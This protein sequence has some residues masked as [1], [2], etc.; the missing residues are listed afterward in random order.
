MIVDDTPANL[1]LLMTILAQEGYRVRPMTQGEAAIAAARAVRPDLI[2][3]DIMMPQMDGYEV[4]RRLKADEETRTIPIIFLSAMDAT[5]S[6]VR[7]FQAGA[8]DFI[9]KPF[10]AEE[11]VARVKTHLT[12]RHLQ[13]ELELRLLDLEARNEELNAFSHTVAHDLKNPVSNIVGFAELLDQYYD[14][15]SADEIR[16]S[17]HTIANNGRK[18]DTIIEEL[19]LLAGIRRQTVIPAELNMVAIVHEVRQRLA[20]LIDQEGAQIEAG[21]PSRWPAAVGH[22]PWVEEVW[23]NYISNAIKYGGTPPRVTLG[24]SREGEDRVRFWVRDNGEGLDAAAQA[25][26]FTPFTQL[27]KIKTKGHG[28]GL[29]IVRRIIDKLQGE[30]GVTSA[31]GEGSTFY[32]IL[33][34]VKAS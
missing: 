12:L 17:I 2:L 32:F 34:A 16:S 20:G 26:L 4:C 25:R 3:L 15:L 21:D 6:K 11:V 9:A 8:V 24:A 33:P 27:S 1:R 31:P 7:A 5:G 13:R 10:Q 29:S 30:V 18:L 28:L 19:M 23:T 14:D 22:A